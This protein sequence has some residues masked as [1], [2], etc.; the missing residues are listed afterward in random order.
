MCFERIL[1]VLLTKGE[2]TTIVNGDIKKH[3]KWGTTY[4]MHKQKNTLDKNMYKIWV[5]R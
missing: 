4:T 2:K 3:Q 1:P 5:G